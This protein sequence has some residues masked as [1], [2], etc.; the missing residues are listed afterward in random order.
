[1][2][3]SQTLEIL[4]INSEGTK[5]RKTTEIKMDKHSP[6]LLPGDFGSDWYDLKTL[7][8]KTNHSCPGIT[9]LYTKQGWE[10][11]AKIYPQ[12]E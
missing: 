4:K 2:R 1:M 7:F 3:L 10:L 6:I 11:N 9:A 8:W 12:K 5:E